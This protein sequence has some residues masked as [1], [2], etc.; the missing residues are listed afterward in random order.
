MW[1]AVGLIGLAVFAIHFYM[2]ARTGHVAPCAA[3]Y[4]KLEYEALGD[5]KNGKRWLVT[6]AGERAADYEA[7]ER[8]DI[9]RCYEIALF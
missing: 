6:E 2:L 9:P 1:K 7:I 3:A 4:A 5:F 8:G